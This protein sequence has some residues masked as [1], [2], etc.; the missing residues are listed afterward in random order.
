MS[1]INNLNIGRRFMVVFLAVIIITAGGLA[2]IMMNMSTQKKAVDSIY[3]VRL[4]GIEKLIEADRDAYQSSIAISQL[5]NAE[6]TNNAD[7]ATIKSL[8]NDI[9]ENIGQNKE[10][11]NAFAK[12]Y[13][14]SGAE[15]SGEFTTIKSQYDVWKGHTDTI[16]DL[17]RQKQY[18]QAYSVYSTDFAKAFSQVRNGMD[19]LTDRSLK[20]TEQEYTSFT[21][22]FFSNMVISS[23]VALLVI[24]FLVFS[25][26]VLTRSITS[27]LRKAVE[28]TEKIAKGD[29]SDRISIEQ[30]DEVG[31][32]MKSLNAAADDLEEL[33]SSVVIAITNLTDMVTQIS[34]GN[35][36]LS[37]RTAEQASALEEIASTLEE[38]T[39]A[40]NLNAE[41]SLQAKELTD[42][43]AV[44]S[45]EGSTIASQAIEAINVMNDSSKKIAEIIS[46][47][48]GIAFQTNL[49]ALNAAVEAA[50]AG[51]QGRGFAVVA[52]EVRNLA[53]RTAGAS[54]EIENLI[55]D[56]V[57][58][59]E[60]GSELV[61]QS[62]EVLG[63]I[64]EST[65]MTAGIITE[66]ATASQE[67]KQG[68]N[69]I[70]LAVTEM[71]NMTQ[72]NA[73]LVEETASASESMASQARELKEL[74][75]R[76]KIKKP[77]GSEYVITDNRLPERR[78]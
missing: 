54:K 60:K 64:S 15:E 70:N 69:Q 18:T 41:H 5:L 13:V 58:K 61:R 68:I 43:G 11:F 66:I 37:Q 34:A 2:F 72:Q 49:L 17:I 9:T 33:I 73:A 39:S 23:T 29:F 56:S 42:Q 51:E 19:K 26:A 57:I 67:H 45:N 28:F 22:E 20:L 3:R 32:M 74:T 35:Q 8:I 25:G 30:K 46:V 38:A 50:R 77:G 4:V 47:I 10:R 78:A 31:V 27:P 76:F 1:L 62:S 16:I 6:L 12:L 44:K 21:N 59:V 65:K 24:I 75:T 55:K 36:S 71:D 40:I 14:S 63:A 7:E 52:G 53:Q 48:N